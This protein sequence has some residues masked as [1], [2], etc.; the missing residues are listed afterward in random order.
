VSL[1]AMATSASS[2]SGPGND[3]Y[4]RHSLAEPSLEKIASDPKSFE[5]LFD[6]LSPGSPIGEEVWDILMLLPT[7]RFSFSSF[8]SF[9]VC[10]YVIEHSY[11]HLLHLIMI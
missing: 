2:G 3:A 1:Q 10:K 8:L 11:E 4:S 5:R 9:F 7:N 6:L